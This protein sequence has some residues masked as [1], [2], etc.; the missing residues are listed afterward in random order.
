M[1]HTMPPS[2]EG[3]R[4]AVAVVNDSPVGCQSRDRPRR[5]EWAA[6]R[7]LGGREDP[8]IPLLWDNIQKPYSFLSLSRLR[9]QL[10][11]QREPWLSAT[12]NSNL[13]PKE[14]YRARFMCVDHRTRWCEIDSGGAQ[15]S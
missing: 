6:V 10:P 9:R 4:S 14:R 7:L 8:R 2:D 13:S 12:L 1:H 5:S 11:H 15:R 3:K